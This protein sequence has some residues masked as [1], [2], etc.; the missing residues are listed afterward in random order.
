MILVVQMRF[1]PRPTCHG[2]DVTQAFAGQG[3]TGSVGLLFFEMHTYIGPNPTIPSAKP[4]DPTGSC[5]RDRVGGGGVASTI[6]LA[7]AELNDCKEL[8]RGK[9]GL[10]IG[11]DLLAMLSNPM[12][13]V[14]SHKSSGKFPGGIQS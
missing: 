9:G 6:S 5:P 13:L 8:I 7:S 10:P 11:Y 3:C 14:G 12:Y 1:G 2:V 4:S